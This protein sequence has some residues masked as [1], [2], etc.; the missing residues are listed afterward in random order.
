[1]K[2]KDFKFLVMT[3]QLQYH[4]N[5]ILFVVVVETQLSFPPL[6]K[7]SKLFH[8]RS[9]H[10]SNSS[11]IISIHLK[12]FLFQ[13]KSPKSVLIDK[14]EIQRDNKIKAKYSTAVSTLGQYFSKSIKP[15]QKAAY[16]LGQRDILLQLGEF[17]W[18]QTNGDP[19]SLPVP[20]IL[21]YLENKLNQL[22]E[23]PSINNSLMQMTIQSQNSNSQN[24][25]LENNGRIQVE[26]E[27]SNQAQ[28]S[29]QQGNLTLNLYNNNSNANNQ[30]KF[31]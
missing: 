15:S 8:N 21:S 9:S 17:I 10:W 16:A 23:S 28:G 11:T 24:I 1:M 29:L 3:E 13:S 27:G 14:M 31:Y 12:F 6:K 19:S 4:L 30:G 25:G 20:D 18:S 5:D 26:N 7:T 2:K 22:E